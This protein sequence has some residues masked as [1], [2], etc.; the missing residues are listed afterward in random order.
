MNREN[1]DMDG[2]LPPEGSNDRKRNKKKNS[3]RLMIF[4]FIILVILCI[5]AG[6]YYIVSAKDISNSSQRDETSLTEKSTI[7]TI[8]PKSDSSIDIT[9]DSATISKTNVN[10]VVSDT[11]DEDSTLALDISKVKSVK[12]QEGAVKFR[13]HMV[14]EGEDLNSIANLYGLKLQTIISVN[15][16]KN[17]SGITEG[18]VLSIPDRNG[19]Y[20]IVK[21]GDM[22]STI[23]NT[24]CPNLGWKTLQEINGLTDT[25]LDIGDKIFI[26]DMSEVNVNPT[27]RTSVNQFIIPTVSGSVIAK[28][29]QFM[30]N[31]PYND[32][33]SLNGVL[34]KSNTKDVLASADGAVVDIQ[35][36]KGKK[37]I[38]LSHEGGYETVYG[39][40]KT[41]ELTIGD[42]VNGSDTLGQLDDSDKKIYFEIIQSGIPLDPESFF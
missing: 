7:E 37:K 5:I 33:I 13:E 10:P 17:I 22:L 12:A 30:E 27:I 16:I 35:N 36:I 41:T 21:S 1:F 34:I 42:E 4:V 3:N 31:N 11:S 14:V 24:Y 32:D 40:L 19:S 38:K 8:E 15:E 23:A 9:S 2:T 6:Y 20:Y 39:N 29:G 18:V 28:Y 26:P 25:K